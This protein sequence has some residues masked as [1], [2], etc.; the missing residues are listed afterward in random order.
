MYTSDQ[1]FS[2]RKMF[3]IK[4]VENIRIHIL[5][6]ITFLKNCA[7]Y[8]IMWKNIIDPGRQQMTVWCMCIVYWIPKATHTHSDYVILIAFS[9]M[10]SGCMNIPHCYVIHTLSA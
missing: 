7:V 6:S 4:V 1:F 8:E 9:T 3:Q 10:T 2:E 5:C